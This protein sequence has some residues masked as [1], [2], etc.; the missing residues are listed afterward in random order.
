MAKYN[1]GES[2]FFNWQTKE[3]EGQVYH[4]LLKWVL[5]MIQKGFEIKFEET[6]ITKLQA[7]FAAIFSYV[8]G[9][10]YFLV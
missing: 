5:E 9:N 10:K 2:F 8:V 7:I 6:I 4:G 1:Q 3:L